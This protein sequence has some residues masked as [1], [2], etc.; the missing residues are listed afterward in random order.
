MPVSLAACYDLD[1]CRAGQSGLS[2]KSALY[3]DQL[4]IGVQIRLLP[5]T[6]C[7]PG[8]FGVFFLT[9]SDV[10]E[11]WYCEPDFAPLRSSN[12]VVGRTVTYDVIPNETDWG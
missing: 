8:D 10:A 12:G 1:L 6:T 2:G 11:E 3:L 7:E 4:A 5:G 9:H